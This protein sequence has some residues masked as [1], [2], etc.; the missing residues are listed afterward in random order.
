MT[1]IGVHLWELPR[2]FAAPAV[3]AA[4]V[5]GNLIGGE[6]SWLLVIAVVC[7]LLVMAW[8]H[9]M[10][11]Y[12]DYYWTGLDKGS[13]G[14]RSR[15]KEYTK[16]QQPIAA[17][18]LSGREVLANALVW[19]CLSAV[20]AAIISWK[21]TAWVWLPWVL[22]SLSTFWYS[23]GKLH[24]CCELALGLGFGPFACML[25]A[26]TASSPDLGLAF[27]AGLP[28]AIVWGY[29]AETM[30]QW[31]D[32]ERASRIRRYDSCFTITHALVA[33][34]YNFRPTKLDRFRHRYYCKSYSDPEDGVNCVGCGRCITWCPAG[35]DLRDV[36]SSIVKEAEEKCK[37]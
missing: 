24:Y 20:M 22:G 5:M 36:V 28:F 9:A 27:L 34:G 14:L 11:T 19:L 4:V 3:V 13:V 10:N 18:I 8:G 33:G 23:W 6:L 17:G 35:I 21:A 7:G 15:P 30:D 31:I 32:A 26:A 2:W 12:L 37:R 29:A 25:G 16:G 1:N